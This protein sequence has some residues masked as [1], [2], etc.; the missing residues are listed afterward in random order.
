MPDKVKNFAEAFIHEFCMSL[1]CTQ[2]LLKA[3]SSN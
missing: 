3:N 1:Q 2:R